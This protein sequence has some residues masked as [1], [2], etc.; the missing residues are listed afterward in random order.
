MAMVPNDLPPIL[1]DQLSDAVA[2]VDAREAHLPLIALNRTC[3]EV[4][5]LADGPVA[6]QPWEVAFAHTAAH[7]VPAQLQRAVATGEPFAI[8]S[9]PYTLGPAVRPPWRPHQ[10]TFWDWQVTPLRDPAGQVA[11]LLVVMV[12]VTTRETSAG[13]GMSGA[14]QSERER[15]AFLSLISHEIRSPLT[16]IKG[17]AQLA[18]R[19]V[20]GLGEG[21][22]RLARQM[23]V[24]EQQAD[25][26]ARL[27]G[28]LSDA[29]RLH[30]DRL[31]LKPAAFDLTTEIRS[32]VE[33]YEATPDLHRVALHAAATPLLVRA[34]P[35]RIRQVIQH[36]L[37][38]AAKYSPEAGQIAVTLEP[39]GPQ[40]RL[41][42]RD[43]GIGIPVDELTRIFGRFYRAS[44]SLAGGL[45]LGLFIAQKIIARSGGQLRV[46]STVGQGSAFTVTLPLA[47]EA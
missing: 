23:R 26:V 4:L 45:G 34:D 5:A 9:L 22:A 15:D 43:R 11:R 38:N 24:I 3:R 19:E 8:G 1:F 20:R 17:F 13:T 31:A 14:T 10:P 25:R 18:L 28:D 47:E 16:S 36:L 42:V 37:A 41:T 33:E 21:H 7:G 6:G 39:Q 46:E 30:E 44:N 32:V 12:D 27:V 35:A 40:A 2:V 29:A